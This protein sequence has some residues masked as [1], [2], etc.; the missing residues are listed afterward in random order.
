MRFFIIQ[1]RQMRLLKKL[2]KKKIKG[3][4]ITD[5]ENV[6]DYLEEKEL[7]ILLIFNIE[8]INMKKCSS[9]GKFTLIGSFSD[10]IT[11]SI[12]FDFILTY[13]SN[14]IKCELDKAEKSEKIEISCKL[15]SSFELVE[16]IL[17]EQ[18]IIKKKYKEIFII[19]KKRIQIS[20]KY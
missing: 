12:I 7:K 5:L 8:S 10:D 15:H 13:P 19:Q 20:N 18:K 6:V 9:T 4:E 11:E 2:K 16:S 14:E 3:E 17:I 1:K